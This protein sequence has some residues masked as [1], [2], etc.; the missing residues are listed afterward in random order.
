MTKPA[1]HISNMTG[2]LDGLRAIS[3]NTRTNAYCIEQHERAVEHD[4]DNI[5]GKCYSHAMLK[6]FRKNMEPALQRNSDLL[7]SR[8]L[9]PHEIPRIV[10]AIFRFD[11]HGELILS[12]IHI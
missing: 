8:P 12:L 5:C 9:E 10:D 7:S 4:T 1:V 11:A 3:T 6:G 2:K